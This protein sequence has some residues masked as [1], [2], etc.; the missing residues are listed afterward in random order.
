MIKVL[1]VQ[2]SGFLG[3]E[4]Q[5]HAGFGKKGQDIVCAAATFLLRTVAQALGKTPGVA[6]KGQAP[7]EGSLSFEARAEG[8]SAVAGLKFA[9]EMIQEG[10]QSLSREFPQNVQFECKLEE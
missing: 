9:A 7:Y 3:C 10:F 6:F 1:L 2:N 4:A 8:D 5:G